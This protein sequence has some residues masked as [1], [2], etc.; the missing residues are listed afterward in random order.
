MDEIRKGIYKYCMFRAT[1]VR[2]LN[3]LYCLAYLK[4]CGPWIDS[5][6]VRMHFNQVLFVSEIPFC[7][8]HSDVL[9]MQLD[10]LERPFWEY[11]PQ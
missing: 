1:N 3:I 8:V 9:W 7:L 5:V 6:F 4:I 10:K 11:P 2:C